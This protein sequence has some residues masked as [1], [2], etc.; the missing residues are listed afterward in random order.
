MGNNT[1]TI[2]KLHSDA[3][4]LQ[5]RFDNL[6]AQDISAYSK[7]FT[8]ISAISKR[9]L[10]GGGLIIEIRYLSGAVALSPICISDGLSAGTLECLAQDIRASHETRIAMNPVKV[11]KL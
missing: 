7:A 10:I 8:E 4:A 1:D 9:C 11:F 3:V 2:A 5:R 6:A